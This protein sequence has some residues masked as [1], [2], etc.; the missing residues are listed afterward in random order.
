MKKKIYSKKQFERLLIKNAD[1]M[2][3]DKRLFKLA[4]KVI[5]ISDKYMYIHQN[6]FFGEYSLNL[7]EDLFKIQELVYNVRPDYIIEIGVAW[8]GT[9]LFL[10]G[11]LENIGHGKIIGVDIYIPSSAKKRI[12]SKGKISKR[13]I[14]FKGSS[15]SKILQ[16]KIYNMSKNKKI[17]II[18]DSNHTKE[19]V[20]KELEFY[21]KLVSKNSYIICCDTILNFIKKNKFRNRP[22]DNKNNPHS[23]VLDFLKI[24][25]NFQID[26]N[27][28]KKLLITCNYNGYL[29]KVYN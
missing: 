18:L 14:L 17:I 8:G 22:W 26:K 28:N 10:A 15:L 12:L 4:N 5:E 3:K 11:V 13:I 19:H 9:T 1:S 6:K 16:N 20:L 23:A 21:S 27:I 25:K 2:S 29:K 24:N 7:P